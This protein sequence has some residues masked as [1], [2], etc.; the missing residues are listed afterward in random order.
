MKICVV[1][2]AYNEES[3]I[4]EFLSELNE[5]LAIW[6]PAF[7]VIDD[8]SSDG[9]A[10]AVDKLRRSG[11][12]AMAVRNE[13]NAGHG[14]STCR[15]LSEGLKAGVD[16]VV[17]VDGDGQF[18]GSDLARVVQLAI[19]AGCDVVEG[20]RRHRGDPIY[21]RFVSLVTRLLVFSKSRKFPLDANTPLRV[22]R[23]EILQRLLEAVDKEGLVPNL[24]ISVLVRRWN[25]RVE[26]VEVES[27]PRRG[28]EKTGTTWGKSRRQLPSRRF[29]KFCFRAVRDFARV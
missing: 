4:G 14:P 1:M 23:P 20:V 6:S 17:A 16:L 13:S 28:A 15:A 3:G 19:D 7:I 18:Y 22:Y 25:V 27:I 8:C 10:Q 11:I 2:P 5:S 24:A 26:S 12:D 29:V 21:R 9:T